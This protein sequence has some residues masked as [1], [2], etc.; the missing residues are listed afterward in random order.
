MPMLKS[1]LSL[2]INTSREEEGI[3]MTFFTQLTAKHSSYRNV[4]SQSL[5]LIL[6]YYS[7]TNLILV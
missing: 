3:C 7:R 4:V 1:K 2:L 5:V 6:V